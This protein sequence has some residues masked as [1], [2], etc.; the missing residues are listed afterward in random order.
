MTFL[1]NNT[2]FTFPPNF[3]KEP[4]HSKFREFI[5]VDRGTKL[6]NLTNK[7]LK[8]LL[9]GDLI[10]INGISGNKKPNTKVDKKELADIYQDLRTYLYMVVDKGYYDADY[11][12]GNYKSYG[13]QYANN[14]LTKY[15]IQPSSRTIR[16]YLLEGV[17]RDFDMKSCH[18]QILLFLCKGYRI[19][20]CSMLEEYVNDSKAFLKKN[21]LTKMNVI[22]YGLYSDEI[23]SD[24]IENIRLFYLELH[25]IRKILIDTDELN[26]VFEFNPNDDNKNK[27]GSWLSNVLCYFESNILNKVMSQIKKDSPSYYDSIIP[28]YDGLMVK[29]DIKFNI[30]VEY[31][32]KITNDIGIFWAEKDVI[33]DPY[34]GLHFNIDNNFQTYNHKKIQWEKTFSIIENPYCLVEKVIDNGNEYI[35]QLN[36][37]QQKDRFSN[38]LCIYHNQNTGIGEDRIGTEPFIDIWLKDTN[39]LSYKSCI[40]NPYNPNFSDPYENNKLVLNTFRGFRSKLVEYDQNDYDIQKFKHH[41]LHFICND[42][43]EYY[44]HIIKW[45]SFTLQRPSERQGT[46]NIFCGREGS[47]KTSIFMFMSW[48]IDSI[49]LPF[50]KDLLY[51]ANIEELSSIAKFNGILDNKLLINLEE[52]DIQ[53]QSK[54]TSTLKTLITDKS[55]IIQKKGI[56]SKPAVNCLSIMGTSNETSNVIQMSNTDRRYNIFKTTDALLKDQ[57]HKDWIKKVSE[58]QDIVN[59]LFS[60]LVGLDIESYN[61]KTIID[62]DIRKQLQ[63]SNIHPLIPFLHIFITEGSSIKTDDTKYGFK[64]KDFQKGFLDYCYKHKHKSLALISTTQLNNHITKNIG[65]LIITQP[66]GKIS[67]RV[68][69]KQERFYMYEFHKKTTDSF[70]KENR[71]STQ[72]MNDDDLEE[73]EIIN[74]TNC[75]IDDVSDSE[76]DNL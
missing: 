22:I 63:E 61:P 73:V 44:Q 65:D 67:K 3:R 71:L 53:K 19:N 54:L 36:I 52:V 46:A 55:I 60:F 39:R 6:L 66:D 23:P 27:C 16:N 62:T 74:N 29:N 10:Y 34:N 68:K 24:V 13:R 38:Q 15:S 4:I 33:N 41:I 21:K 17:Y 64:V 9:N 18:F 28:Y 5:N 43:D 32:N 8:R 14:T 48:I 72:E 51:T 75:Y 49:Y 20:E 70:L 47:G 59:K 2:F 69:H 35:Q 57:K 40:F 56:D 30:N 11:K 1:K 45:L 26:N 12:F 7:N 42:N 58:S 37:K 76:D 50:D 31:F 25:N